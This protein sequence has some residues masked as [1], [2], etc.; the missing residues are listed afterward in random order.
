MQH[1]LGPWPIPL[2][3]QRAEVARTLSLLDRHYL[4]QHNEESET[5]LHFV[6]LTAWVTEPDADQP[7]RLEV[8]GELE[9][10]LA[11]LRLFCY[12]RG[13]EVPDGT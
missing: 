12:L 3:Q 7:G 9:Y 8:T 5:G 13:V 4:V 11:N 2:K 10:V 1:I 6:K